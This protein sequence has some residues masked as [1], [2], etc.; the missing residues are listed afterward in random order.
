MRDTLRQ[1]VRDVIRALW[2]VYRDP[3]GPISMTLTFGPA[4][5]RGTPAEQVQHMA[6]FNLPPTHQVD[7]TLKITDGDGNP[8]RIDGLPVWSLTDPAIVTLDVAT[9][10]LS[11]RIKATGEEGLTQVSAEV[12]ADRGEGVRTI[13]AVGDIAVLGPEASVVEMTFGA[14]EPQAPPV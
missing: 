13:T 8:A 4:V 2:A 9:D 1:F 14:S 3:R 5:P 7:V 6:V 10:G 11:A 12:D